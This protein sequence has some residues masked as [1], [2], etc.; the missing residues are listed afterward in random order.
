MLLQH[1]LQVP[2]S[3]LLAHDTDELEQ[4][5]VSRFRQLE[6]ERQQGVPMAYILG[7]RE[8]MGMDFTVSPDVLIP[9]PET[10]LLVET[11]LEHL[12]GRQGA[13]VLDL[14]TGSGAIA[15][16]IAAH[17]P[18]LRVYATDVS[19]S[20]LSVAEQNAQAQGVSVRF[21]SGNWYDALA[22]GAGTGARDA[23]SAGCQSREPLPEKFDLIVSNPPY[24]RAD[25]SH[26]GQGDLRYEPAMAL[27]DGGNG[28]THLQ[29][30]IQGAA[31]RLAPG[32]AV[33][34]EHGWDQAAAV[35]Q[36]L[37][38]AG[39]RSVRS[40]KDLAQIERISGGSI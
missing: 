28:L 8:F 9:R 30:I 20:A 37:Q 39:F 27:T 10:E 4:E 6:K 25:D 2:R 29:T 17:R 38:D 16:A 33:W 26:L 40:V 22:R 19:A 31:N 13:S 12:A 18:D 36:L 35:R 5:Q 1:V 32:G 7:Q 21:L 24:I 23:S 3:W 14:G 15:V 34:V 11:A